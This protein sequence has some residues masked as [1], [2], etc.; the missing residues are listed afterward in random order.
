[1]AEDITIAGHKVN[2]WVV[3]GGAGVAVVAGVLWWRSRNA[4]SSTGS[5]A[6][7]STQSGTDPVTGLP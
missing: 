1:M 2:K 3:Y 5:T 6:A 7:G 4:S